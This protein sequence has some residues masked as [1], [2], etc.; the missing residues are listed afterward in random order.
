MHVRYHE[1]LSKISKEEPAMK[2]LFSVLFSLILLSSCCAFAEGVLVSTPVETN[3]SAAAA[4]SLVVQDMY[5]YMQNLMSFGSIEQNKSNQSYR[6]FSGG[7]DCYSLIQEYVKVL[8]GGKY[9]FKLVD[10]YYQSY[11]NEAFFSYALDYIGTGRVHGQK[12][13]MNFKDGVY[14]HVTIWGTVER[15]KAEG[16]IYAADGLEFGDLGLRAGGKTES[17]SL[18]GQSLATDL[19]RLSDGSYKTGDGRFHVKVGQATVYRDGKLLTT[20]ATLVRNQAKN[21]E[22]LRIFNFYNNESIILTVPYNSVVT[23]DVLDQ[24]TI[25]NNDD[26]NGFDKYMKN[27]ED[28]LDWKFSD[29]LLGVCHDGEY[30]LC[31]CDDYNEFDKVAVRIMYWDKAADVAVIYI[32]ATF[33]SAPYEYEALAAVSLGGT[34]AGANADEVFSMKAGQSLD[35]R[36]SATEFMPSHELFTWEILEGSSL[37]EL[38]GTR[39]QTCTVKAYDPG[40][41]RLKVTYEYGAK[42]ANVLTGNEETK[43]M[44][45][46]REYVI[47]IAP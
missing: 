7:K 32:C 19:Y 23:G 46:T 27:M 1:H 31:Y 25:G 8:T 3:S 4:D 21:R 36:F 14:G 39:S 34:P 6:R 43:F 44:S 13:E 28:F 15:S 37:I 41:V 22:E 29:K 18:P 45:K 12:S 10:S 9:N 17:V 16:Y 35:I 11:G 33:D 47:N 40:T 38:T 26:D 5:S 42:G 24:R 30:F 20:D 2:K